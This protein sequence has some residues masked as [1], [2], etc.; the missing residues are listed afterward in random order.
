MPKKEFVSASEFA[1]RFG[2]SEGAIRRL[3]RNGIIQ[4]RKKD[5]KIDWLEMGRVYLLNRESFPSEKISPNFHIPEDFL[6]KEEPKEEE[7]PKPKPKGRPKTSNKPASSTKKATTKKSPKPKAK[8]A[9]T[10]KKNTIEKKE[11]EITQ[12][13]SLDTDSSNLVSFEENIEDFDK[14]MKNLEKAFE[15][16]E[17]KEKRDPFKGYGKIESIDD[18]GIDLSYKGC[19]SGKT[20]M[21]NMVKTKNEAT[22]K[23]IAILKQL[24]KL[25]PRETAKTVIGASL[26]II[27]SQLDNA[28]AR[29]QN[30]ITNVCNQYFGK[31]EF[32]ANLY[33]ALRDEIQE[34]IGDTDKEILSLDEKFENCEEE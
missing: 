15:D 31:P 23:Q 11:A 22:I 17:F 16:N 10:K 26:G 24:G 1:R 2:V 8:K 32:E 34:I 9:T 14:E 27:K 12:E 30:T 25:I 20:I 18:M 7:K 28:P 3:I 5:K 19:K 4:R 29:L 21:W 6:E 13:F 33:N